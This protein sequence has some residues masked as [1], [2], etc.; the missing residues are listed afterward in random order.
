MTSAAAEGGSGVF[1]VYPL[2]FQPARLLSSR[3]SILRF[4]AISGS[5]HREPPRWIARHPRGGWKYRQRH[6]AGSRARRRDSRTLAQVSPDAPRR[7]G[8]RRGL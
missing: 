2:R 1:R 5:F 4:A 7:L 3:S 8:G 6:R